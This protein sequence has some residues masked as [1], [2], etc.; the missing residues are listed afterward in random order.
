MQ[1]AKFHNNRLLLRLTGM[2][3][4]VS[5]LSACGNGNDASAGDETAAEPEAPAIPVEISQVQIGDV[6]AS[7]EGTATLEAEQQAT[8]V[9]KTTGVIL[10]ILVEEGD[11]VQA[12]EIIARLE[13]NQYRLEVER[14]KATLERLENGLKRAT[15]LHSR[16]LMSAEEYEQTR[17]DTESQRAAFNLAKLDLDH[18][19]IRAPI[20][21]V[22]S[23]RMVKVGNLVTLHQAVFRIDDFDPLWAVLHVPERELNTLNSGQ[24]VAVTLDAYPDATFSGHVLRISP[25]VDPATGTFK[26]TA[27]INDDSG[28]VKPGLFGRVRIIYDSRDSVAL[29]AKNAVLSEDGR[30]AVFVV[31]DDQTVERKE[32]EVGYEESGMMEVT[33]GL[34]PGDTV[35]TAGKGSLRDGAKVE[36]VEP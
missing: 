26:V 7:Y 12:G 8:V 2:M 35:V 29:V 18:T 6:S 3:I 16:K 36:V 30:H 1:H 21:G 5:L 22:I 14:A 4:A 11:V 23:E 10:E 20:S 24:A 33:A 27:E 19:E 34:N 9:A 15:E 31:N 13:R 32:I 25:V 17:F 28:R